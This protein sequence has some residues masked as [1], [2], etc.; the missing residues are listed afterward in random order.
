MTPKVEV[1]YTILEYCI[2]IIDAF[3][4]TYVAGGKGWAN[5]R[6]FINFIIILSSL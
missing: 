6:C 1:Y 3:M 2:I 4:C 5:F